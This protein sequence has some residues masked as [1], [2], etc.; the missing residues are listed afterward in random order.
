M[1]GQEMQATEIGSVLEDR[2][3]RMFFEI[4]FEPIQEASWEEAES[5]LEALKKRR[6]EQE[7]ANV[8]RN[9]EANPS[10]AAMKELL[11]RKQELLRQ[12]TGS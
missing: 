6:V 10:G 11:T 4:L 7:L 12:L 1:S 8:Q 3:R 5:C 2:D 9:I